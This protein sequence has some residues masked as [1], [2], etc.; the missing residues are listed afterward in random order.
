MMPGP[1][2][3]VDAGVVQFAVVA[4]ASRRVTRNCASVASA[5]TRKVYARPSWRRQNPT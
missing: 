5:V 3:V 4:P 1:P 2:S